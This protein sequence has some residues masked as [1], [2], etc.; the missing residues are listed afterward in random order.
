MKILIKATLLT[1]T[2][3]LT[4]LYAHGSSTGSSHSH[5]SPVLNEVSK[6]TVKK[7][8]QQEVKR[9]AVGKK[10]DNSWLFIPVSKM[11]KQ[12]FAKSYE[13]VVSFK[14]SEIKERAKQT[15]YIF[16]DL[17]GKVTGANYTGK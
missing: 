2:L 3:G 6:A 9:L 8:A 1:L 14:N 16:I 17:Q 13:W 12:Q 15:L 11:N 7:T 10:I 5:I 4:T